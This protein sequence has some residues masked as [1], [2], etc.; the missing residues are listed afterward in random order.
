MMIYSCKDIVFRG[1]LKKD[2]AAVPVI[3]SFEF[4]SNKLVEITYGDC[5]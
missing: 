2:Y 1:V 5:R 3:F 4:T